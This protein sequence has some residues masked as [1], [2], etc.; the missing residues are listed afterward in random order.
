MKRTLVLLLL[1]A[2]SSQ[3]AL[4]G[5]SLPPYVPPA[6]SVL[7][8]APTLTDDSAAGR[9]V[10][11]QWRAFGATWTA[12]SVAPGAATWAI[13]YPSGQAL[14]PGDALTGTP[15]VAVGIHRLYKAYVG[16]V[17]TLTRSLDSATQSIGFAPG[18][19]T[20]DWSVGD[21]FCNSGGVVNGNGCWVSTLYDQRAGSGI[22]YV[23]ATKANGAPW[24]NHRGVSGQRTL[25]FN[26]LGRTINGTTYPN[27]SIFMT[28][29]PAPSVTP[30]NF[31][32]AM[33][34]QAHSTQE[35]GCVASLGAAN[36]FNIYLANDGADPARTPGLTARAS[37]PGVPAPVS[38][39]FY[40]WWN[41]G[42]AISSQANNAK[43]ATA[44]ASGAGVS[45]LT[46]FTIGCPTVSMTN[47]NAD[48]DLSDL[49]AFG[50]TPSTADRAIL[51][52]TMSELYN[53]PTQ[54]NDTLIFGGD[55][56]TSNPRSA[57][58]QG[59]SQ[60][61]QPDLSQPMA[62]YNLAIFGTTINVQATRTAPFA[63]I[64]SLTT[65]RNNFVVDDLGGNDIRAAATAT[66][67]EAAYVTRAAAIRSVCP[68]A[69]ILLQTI[70]SPND[71]ASG[72]ANDITRIAINSWIRASAVGAGAADAVVDIA[73][74]PILGNYALLPGS[75]G[76]VDGQH[77]TDY[78]N[79][80]VRNIAAPV[81]NQLAR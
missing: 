79:A 66:T 21:A 64:C 76:A 24:T 18:T 48:Y 43:S 41:A 58:R 19:N 75:V 10:G 74:D 42:G 61:V 29:T 4:A 30:F 9:S 8:R 62:T 34:G 37:T 32:V 26:A 22:T 15:M 73:A 44:S 72:S 46:Q 80:L 28:M 2:L 16:N 45:A 67:I 60:Q 59:F 20:I 70:S 47:G 3:A 13:T 57:L 39:S 36:E 68:R 63:A 25:L 27:T 38:P 69:R 65:T 78:G 54:V 31:S 40:G 49:F 56:F 14:L 1:A 52:A 23:Q 50:S 71:F 81:I 53:V 5:S 11:D 6:I 55:S 51:Q 33:T 7:Q 77:L 35:T 12:T 17:L